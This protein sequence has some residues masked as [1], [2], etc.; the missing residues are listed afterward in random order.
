MVQNIRL[1]KFDFPL[2][3]YPF[4]SVLQTSGSIWFFFIPRVSP[5]AVTE[6]PFRS[7]P[8][9]PERWT[10]NNLAVPDFTLY[11]LHSTLF[12]T[13]DSVVLS[14]FSSFTPTINSVALCVFLVVLGVTKAKR[15]VSFSFY[16]SPKVEGILHRLTI[17]GFRPT[18]QALTMTTTT[19]RQYSFH[20]SLASSCPYI[21]S[22]PNALK[23]NE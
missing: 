13:T 12:I 14:I 19:T 23:V 21:S 11:I 6:R 20:S 22:I 9:T 8:D 2:P 7:F 17:N 10:F 1:L 18:F 16:L 5:W 3:P 15:S 4:N